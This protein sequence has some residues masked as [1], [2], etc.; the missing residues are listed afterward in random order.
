M[1]YGCVLH[2]LIR[3]MRHC[4]VSVQRFFNALPRAFMVSRR[5]RTSPPKPMNMAMV[6][7]ECGPKMR[8]R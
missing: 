4:V 3:L 5:P 7:A 6:K 1:Q 2:A 8:E